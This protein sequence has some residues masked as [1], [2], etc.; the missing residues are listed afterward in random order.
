MSTDTAGPTNYEAVSVG[1]EITYTIT[2]YNYYAV[3]TD[4]TITDQLDSGVEFVSATDRDGK[5]LTADDVFES[6]D[7]TYDKW[8]V[9]TAE[10]YESGSVT[11]TVRVTEDAKTAGDGLSSEWADS[12]TVDNQASVQ[13]GNDSAATTNI[14]TNP[15]TPDDPENPSK[16]IYYVEDEEGNVQTKTDGKNL[17][18]SVGD[19][20]T[21]T[22]SYYNHNSTPAT[23]TITDTLDDGVDFVSATDGNGNVV[24]KATAVAGTGTV[25]YDETNHTV[26]WT[27]ENA[28][29]FT[30]GSVTLTVRVNDDAKTANQTYSAVDPTDPDVYYE[31]TYTEVA[32]I[33]NQAAVTIVANTSDTD[34]E[35]DPEETEEPAYTN[36]PENPLESE[37]PVNPTKTISA[38][39]PSGYDADATINE[40]TNTLTGSSVGIGSMITYVISYYNYNNTAAD[41]T[42]TDKLDAGVTY[43]DSSDN[44]VYDEATHTVTWTLEN[45]TPLTEGT[46][47]LA[48]QVNEN[49]WIVGDDETTATVEN[50][51]SVAINNDAA[52]DTNKV[53]N[54][55]DPDDPGDPEK[56]VSADSEAGVNG[57]AV[58][59]GDQITYT[60]AYY[61]H[62]NTAV[63][64]IIMD[65]LDD[66]VD[67]VS[68]SNSGVYDEEDHTVTWTFEDVDAFTGG[69]VTLTVKVNSSTGET[70]ENDADVYIGGN[71]ATTNLVT[72]PVNDD[73]VDPVKTVE[74]DDNDGTTD[75]GDLVAV[76]DELVYTITYY[77]YLSYAA[78]VIITDELDEG[79]DY[80]K[81]DN[82][83]V[84][85]SDI[86]TVTWTLEGVNAYTEGSVTLTVKVNENAKTLDTGD[87]TASVVNDALVEI[88]KDVGNTYSRMTNEVENPIESDAPVDPTKTV[89]VGSGNSVAVGDELVYTISYYNYNNT[90]ATVT[91]TDA[92]DAGV[93]YVS[94]SPAGV[95]DTASH[96][97]TWT[98]AN[99]EAFTSGTVT[100]TVQVNRDAT[101]LADGETEGDVV[102]TASVQIGNAAAVDTNKVEN[103]VPVEI[104]EDATVTV[105]KTL[106]WDGVEITAEDYTFYVALY[107]D[108]DCTTRMTEVKALTFEN[109]AS[110]SVTFTGLEI[111]RTYYV[112]ECEED[113]T[114]ILSGTI[115]DGTLFAV[116]F[117]NDENSVTI[118]DGMAAEI[119]FE[120]QFVEIPTGF[121]VQ[122]YL[123]ITKILLDADGSA[124]AS[125]AVFYAGIFTDSSYTTLAENVSTNIVELD[126]AADGSEGSE[127]SVTIDVAAAGDE[128]TVLYVTEVEIDEDGN[129]VPV[130]D[131]ASFGYTVSYSGSEVTLTSTDT[132]ATVTIT[133]KEIEEEEE[134]E[135]ESET[136]TETDTEEAV[137]TGDE[138]PL[139]QYFAL[140]LLA[141]AIIVAE[142]F[143]LRRRE[144]GARD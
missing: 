128:D 63:N 112:S 107:A 93:D 51:A 138:T 68:S 38:T 104:S 137:Q 131:D 13:I 22:I 27:I 114:A 57:S 84:Y 10:A 135:S 141:L 54:P 80:V 18:V 78:T 32:S 15:L 36:V 83:G 109:S 4:I 6:N 142:M 97:V 1:D 130:A 99:V 17:Y 103:P 14:V 43:L 122:G 69:Y 119:T 59:H 41:V 25:V 89:A 127:V 92:L 67:Y 144:R 134:T 29:P 39:S 33:A 9:F 20:V 28:S 50:T 118:A 65:E 129:V 55:I 34:T 53:E 75:D 71:S 90:A 87:T 76:G 3:E 24:N 58:N 95:Y 12:T 40:T 44:G 110:E 133:N 49:A 62:T 143:Y 35:T 74:I 85:D 48:V 111:G 124:L 91:I 96:T 61:N 73:P 23:V 121:Y 64:V 66:G 140:L 100:L 21:Y 70:V 31:F 60:I 105:T 139:A 113:G 7:D 117:D 30:E 123:T 108:E 8:P 116:T 52:V 79:V 46:V 125:D 82:G 120:N 37:D 11:L 2:Y 16:A 94:S 19:K 45:V 47:T 106:T 26:T 101:I 115:S 126:L 102:N 42:I 98:L 77:N 81:S 136:E 56:A 86:H 5:E 132:E 72:N 88:G